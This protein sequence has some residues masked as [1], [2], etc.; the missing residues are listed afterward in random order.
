MGK[1]SWGI[2]PATATECLSSRARI[3]RQQSQRQPWGRR[4]R[5]QLR[6]PRGQKPGFILACRPASACFA[7]VRWQAR[8]ARARSKLH[9][10]AGARDTFPSARARDHRRRDPGAT[11]H[12]QGGAHPRGGCVGAGTSKQSTREAAR[13]DP[14]AAAAMHA[15]DPC[16]TAPSPMESLRTTTADA[17]I[18]ARIAPCAEGAESERV[19]GAPRVASECHPFNP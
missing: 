2:N 5:A 4:K 15:A 11:L 12:C 6:H 17:R 13:G 16:G 10:R 9:H 7:K 8:H 19:F 18:V 3:V 14:L 1:Q